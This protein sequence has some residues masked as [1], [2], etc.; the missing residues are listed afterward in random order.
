MIR[1]L[2]IRLDDKKRVVRLEAVKCRSQW[3][4]DRDVSTDMLH[5]RPTLEP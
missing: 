3:Y 1:Q 4:A 2:L 5:A